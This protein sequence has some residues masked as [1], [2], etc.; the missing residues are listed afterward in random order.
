VPCHALSDLSSTTIVCLLALRS[1][2]SEGRKVTTAQVA[3][4]LGVSTRAASEM[5]GRRAGD[6]RRGRASR[7]L[8]PATLALAPRG[9]AGPAPFQRVPWPG[10]P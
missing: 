6:R 1:A 7:C 10:T 2:G 3:R 5:F 4:H 9:A 8:R